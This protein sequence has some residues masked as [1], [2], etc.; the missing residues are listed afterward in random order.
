M[1]EFC[2]F[3]DSNIEPRKNIQKNPSE[4]ADLQMNRNQSVQSLEHILLTNNMQITPSKRT[5]INFNY[6]K[7]PVGSNPIFR[8]NN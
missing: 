8:T 6:K 7:I 2:G 5:K 1:S 4:K 3:D